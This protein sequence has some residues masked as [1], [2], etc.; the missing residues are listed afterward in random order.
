MTLHLINWANPGP[1]RACRNKSLINDQDGI[2]SQP[3]SVSLCRATFPTWAEGSQIIESINAG[4]VTVLPA[5]FDCIVS[6][7]SDL[8]QL[9]SGHFDKSSLRSMPLTKRAWAIT[10]KIHFVVLTYMPVVPSNP[11]RALGF[12]VIDLGRIWVRHLLTQNSRKPLPATGVVVLSLVHQESAL[13]EFLPVEIVASDTHWMNLQNRL[14]DD[15][16]TRLRSKQHG[17]DKPRSEGVAGIKFGGPP[18][19]RT[20]DPLIK[21]QLLYQLS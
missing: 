8:H 16:S 19:T 17:L 13:P 21:S 11:H 5:H 10:A 18:E 2:R 1:A 20:P 9:R 6:N 12:Q 4:A 14:E 15:Y 3:L 7:R